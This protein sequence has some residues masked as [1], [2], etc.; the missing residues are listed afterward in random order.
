[1]KFVAPTTLATD[2]DVSEWRSLW[3]RELQS[4]HSPYK[5]MIDASM[6]VVGEDQAVAQ[7]LDTMHRFLKGLFLR[8]AVV[9]GSHQSLKRLPFEVFAT[10]A[11][12]IDSLGVR[13]ANQATPGNFRSSIQLENHFQQH[14]MELHFLTIQNITTDSEVR[15]L[16]DKITNNLMQ[17]H[18]KWN[19][20]IDCSNVTMH[21][22]VFAAV[23]DMMRFFRGF[24]LKDVIGYAPASPE[25][26]YPF[27]VFRSRHKAVAS[28]ENEGLSSG[29]TANCASRKQI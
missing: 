18:S 14:V 12:A 23:N 13:V 1:M 26:P 9:F 24:F 22:Q 21:P 19:L 10:E 16:R 6:L 17:W 4:W 27:P 3:M 7:S 2:K 15:I 28:L 5:A 20:L 8:K 29:E 25:T 11:E